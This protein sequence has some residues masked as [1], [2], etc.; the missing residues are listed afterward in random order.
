MS[1]S[2]LI[3]VYKRPHQ[4]LKITLLLNRWWK[5]VGMI[6]G[7]TDFLS[8][9]VVLSPAAETDQTWPLTRGIFSIL[10]AGWLR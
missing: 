7:P 1:P 9:S 3:N 4:V 6:G 8:I 5:V 10:G 2:A